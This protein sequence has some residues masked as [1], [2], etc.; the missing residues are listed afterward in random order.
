MTPLMIANDNEFGAMFALDLKP[1]E[2]NTKNDFQS[3]LKSDLSS[4]L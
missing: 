2:Q 4:H 3:H 1:N